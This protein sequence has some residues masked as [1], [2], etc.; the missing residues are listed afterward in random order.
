VG[1]VRANWHLDH[2]LQDDGS[3]PLAGTEQGRIEELGRPIDLSGD[4]AELRATLMQLLEAESQLFDQGVT[5]PIKDADDT[6]C[7]VCPMK[8]SKG[9]LCEVGCEQERVLTTLA[10][11]RAQ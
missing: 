9:K 10:V 2:L 1:Q 7:S 11:A 4:T 8:G 5:C 6:C 3:D